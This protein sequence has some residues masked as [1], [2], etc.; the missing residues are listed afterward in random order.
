MKPAH[1]YQYPVSFIKVFNWLTWSSRSFIVKSPLW[2]IFEVPANEQEKKEYGGCASSPFCSLLKSLYEDETVWPRATQKSAT[3]IPFLL[4]NS[5]F[6][7]NVLSGEL[8]SWHTGVTLI[9]QRDSWLSHFKSGYRKYTQPI[10]I[11]LSSILSQQD[12]K[13]IITCGNSCYWWD[14]SLNYIDFPVSCVV[15]S[16]WVC[17]VRH[18]SFSTFKWQINKNKWM[19]KPN[20][21]GS[22]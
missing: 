10:V 14:V 3:Q 1:I 5:V 15:T 16:V 2:D 19:T 8:I 4:A 20:C 9:T 7:V 6:D 12:V 22:G 18:C 11:L 17:Y 21:G 13:E